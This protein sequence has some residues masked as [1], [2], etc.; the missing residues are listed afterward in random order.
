MKLVVFEWG[1]RCGIGDILLRMCCTKSTVAKGKLHSAMISGVRRKRV[2]PLKQFLVRK[3]RTA[4]S[5]HA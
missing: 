2:F 5:S 1:D 3:K 4:S